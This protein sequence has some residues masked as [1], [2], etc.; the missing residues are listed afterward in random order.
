[1]SRT[2]HVDVEY[3]VLACSGRDFELAA[4]GAVV[5]AEHLGV[6]QKLAAGDALLEVLAGNEVIAGSGLFIAARRARGVGNRKTQPG[7]SFIRRET[8]VDLPEPDGAEMMKTVVSA[9][10]QI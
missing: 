3:E 5:V 9:L 7:T 6:L 8:M 1:M 10:L 4:V 2:L